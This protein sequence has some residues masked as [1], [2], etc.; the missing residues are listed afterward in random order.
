VATILSDD[1]NKKWT[2]ALIKLVTDPSIAVARE[3]AT[4][5]GKIGDE[6]ARGPLIEA[7]KKADKDNRNKFIEALRDGI[8]GEGLVLALDTVVSEPESTNWFQHRQLFSMI[9][10]LADPRAGDAIVEW[11]ERAKPHKHW[12]TE[13]GIALA[14]IGDVRGAKYIGMR[15][16]VPPKDVYIKEK[17]WQADEGGHMLKTD[18]PRVIGARMLADLA[19]MHPSK[20]PEL[21]EFA[22]QPVID[23]L[24][25][26]PQ[27][28]ANGL[29]FL[30]AAKS[31]K[32]VK[33]MRDWAFPSAELPV[34]GAQPPFPRDFETAQSALRYIGWMQDDQSYDKLVEQFGRKDDKKMDITQNGLMGAGLAMLGM[35]LRAV[36]FGA[37]EGLSQWGAVD[38]PR[39]KKAID[40]LI[41]FIEDETWHEEARQAGCY[42]LA[43]LADEE[44]LTKVIE[45]VGTFAAESD[46][47]KQLIGGCYAGTLSRAPIP[48]AV[49]MLV[50]LMRP[51]LEVSVRN[52]LAH[53]IGVTGLG[54]NADATNKLFEMLKN[55]E[56]RN[57]AALALVLGGNTDTASRTIAMFADEKMREAL[58]DL[59]DN[60]YRAFGYWSDRDLRTGNIFRWVENANA[61]SR[62]KIGGAPQVWAV[63][64][65]QAQFDNLLFDNG[66]HSE[67]R[68]VLRYRLVSAAKKGDTAQKKGALMTLKFMREQGSLMALKDEEGETGQMAAKAFHQLMNP[69]LLEREDLSKFKDEKK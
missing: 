62:V 3:A 55:P 11:L 10:R 41:E 51:E 25:S 44:T 33:Q 64:R 1:A 24:D 49:G 61:I 9:H 2:P 18:R 28:H 4:G 66:P 17:F 29:R 54:D 56:M 35:A 59:K 39:N 13:A 53:A 30:A 22:E 57:P 23:W 26:K 40:T 69:A 19:V 60:Y 21:K 7:L 14:E 31:E 58:P 20:L 5:L 46:P 27:P 67:T 36:A 68:V 15:M 45:K 8:G 48:S 65:L 34:E 37:A 47:K 12:E 50:D 16:T 32:M 43:W 38:G 63:Q 42:A 52:M 6:T